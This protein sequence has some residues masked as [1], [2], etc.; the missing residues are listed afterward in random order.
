VRT[1]GRLMIGLVLLGL[2]AGW[3]LRPRLPRRRL[4]AVIAL[5]FLPAAVHALGTAWWALGVG[6]TA[7]WVALYAVACLAL[8]TL[9]W[10][11]LRA[12]ASRRPFTA[13]LAVPV[14]AFV[15]VALTSLLARAPGAAGAVVDVL[16]GVVL[17][18]AGV[19][20]AAA[21]VVLLPTR[22][23]FP[24]F[25]IPTPRWLQALGRTMRGRR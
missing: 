6:I 18:G 7:A 21:L 25:G 12:S 24:R 5:A 3:I 19:M 10:W 1:L 23:H 8:V 14:Q 4:P 11:L 2:V 20:V 15:Q 9:G 22:D 13:P 17:V 16:S